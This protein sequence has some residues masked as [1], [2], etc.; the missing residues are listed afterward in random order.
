VT[1]RTFCA[2]RWQVDVDDNGDWTLNDHESSLAAAGNG[3]ADL[4]DL[5]AAL[6]HMFELQPEP[7]R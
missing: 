2:G 5:Y 6:G 3:A 4:A 1:R 7:G